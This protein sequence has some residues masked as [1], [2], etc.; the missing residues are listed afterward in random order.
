MLKQFK[1]NEYKTAN[2]NEIYFVFK[3]S[4]ELPFRHGIKN[5]LDPE[6]T[7]PIITKHEPYNN[8]ELSKK[9]GF[10][11]YAGDYDT[12]NGKA[13]KNVD[14]ANTWILG[15]NSWW[16]KVGYNGVWRNTNAK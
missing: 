4:G 7:I 5:I 16:K 14:G 11:C 1:S 15:Y 3:Y 6:N 13:F 10:Y 8:L 9:Y 2:P 12:Y